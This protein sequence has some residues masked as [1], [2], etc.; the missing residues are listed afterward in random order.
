MV[1]GPMF[2][3]WDTNKEGGWENYRQLT[4]DNP[5]LEEVANDASKDPDKMMKTIDKELNRIKFVSLV[6]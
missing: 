5:K 1:G 4:E 2:T 6:K 3:I